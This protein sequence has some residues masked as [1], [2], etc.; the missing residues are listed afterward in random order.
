[1]RTLKIDNMTQKESEI[2]QLFKLSEE[3]LYKY[4]GN[5]LSAKQAMPFHPDELID[6]GKRF[7]EAQKSKLLQVICT[8]DKIKQLTLEETDNSKI[9]VEILNI[10]SS[11]ILPISL[12]GIVVLILKKGLKFSC[13]SY[14]D[15]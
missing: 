13:S 6:R 11:I 15:V 7:F 1:M 14:W 5:E 12:V 3:D 2:E 8:N 10:V 4:I 9:A